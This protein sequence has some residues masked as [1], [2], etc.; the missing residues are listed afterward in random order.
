ME[1]YT[2]KDSRSVSLPPRILQLGLHRR[3]SFACDFA[4]AMGIYFR[5]EGSQFDFG[6]FM[7]ARRIMVF[8]SLA[9]DLIV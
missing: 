1:F 2:I 8:F 3:G 6:F 5:M 7:V 4:S 9:F